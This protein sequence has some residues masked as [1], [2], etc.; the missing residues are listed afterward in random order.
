[1]LSS[2]NL[3]AVL[4]E[5]EAAEESGL[6]SA[7]QF[8]GYAV[9]ALFTI[10]NLLVAYIVIKKFVFKPIMGIIAK[11]ED[12]I[13]QS[14]AD[15]DAS[16]TEAA[17]HEEESRK[18]ID[19][20]RVEASNI[21]EES[22]VNAEKQAEIII[23]KAKEE[24]AEILKRADED[25]KRMKMAALNEMKDELS[26]LA[27]VIAGRVLGDALSVEELKPIADKQTDRVLSEEVNKL[28]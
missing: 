7:D 2:I 18:Y 3:V 9:T 19:E 26:D 11:R 20:A 21:V 13:K 6:F 1:M 15:A 8:G 14:M 22:K 12:M 28:G 27:V 5:A 4:L 23:S 16:K 24:A 25:T 17:K 10:I